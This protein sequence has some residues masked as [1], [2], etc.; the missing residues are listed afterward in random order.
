MILVN[1]YTGQVLERLRRTTPPVVPHVGDSE[2]SDMEQLCLKDF[3]TRSL[4]PNVGRRLT[5]LGAAVLLLEMATTLSIAQPTKG[6]DLST[7]IEQLK[8]A[9]S[10]LNRG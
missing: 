2:R 7:I 3:L 5:E 8:V 6:V 9:A 4:E 10:R 1:L